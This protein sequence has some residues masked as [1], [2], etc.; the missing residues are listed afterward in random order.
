MSK[1]KNEA[2]ANFIHNMKKWGS[3]I[4][5]DEQRILE[6]ATHSWNRLNLYPGD[7]AGAIINTPEGEKVVIFISAGE[8]ECDIGYLDLSYTVR[9]IKFI[10]PLEAV[11]RSKG[12][13]LVACSNT[14]EPIPPFA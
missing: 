10:T 5:T 12:S 14:L 2:A 8:V 4:E 11:Q 9:Q 7:A 1:K 3:R 6:T 13:M